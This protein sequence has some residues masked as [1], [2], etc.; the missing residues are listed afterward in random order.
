LL[1]VIGDP[2]VLGLDPLWRSFLNYVHQNNGW[3]GAPITW[4][5]TQPVDEAGGYDRQ[6]RE[7]AQLDMNEFSRQMEA[8][9]L[10]GV[11]GNEDEGNVDRPWREVE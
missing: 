10:A 7:A 8:L 2:N 11:E 6:V 1:I 9:T 5:P 4:D 3:T